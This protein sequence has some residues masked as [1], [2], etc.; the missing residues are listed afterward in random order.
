[1][2]ILS[3]SLLKTAL[4]YVELLFGNNLLK[5]TYRTLNP[6]RQ[7]RI[8]EERNNAIVTKVI[9]GNVYA[10]YSLW[11]KPFKIDKPF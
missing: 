10:S 1:M 5:V 6:R 8:H 9:T 3:P 2:K 7:H 11:I 4:L